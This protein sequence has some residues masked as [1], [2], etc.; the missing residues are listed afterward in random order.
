VVT[1]MRGKAKEAEDKVKEKVKE[2]ASK[3]TA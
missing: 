1:E 2:K 3:E